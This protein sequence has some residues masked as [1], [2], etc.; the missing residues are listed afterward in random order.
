MLD[1]SAVQELWS[2]V[3]RHKKVVLKSLRVPVANIK[4]SIFLFFCVASLP[5]CLFS[6]APRSRGASSDS[7]DSPSASDVSQRHAV[8]SMTSS[9]GETVEQLLFL[10][11]VLT[12][13]DMVLA[14]LKTIRT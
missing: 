2:D 1:F 11:Y 4:L 6:A 12:Y 9:D 14:N 10:Y 5:I 13:H 8:A 3:R 7:G